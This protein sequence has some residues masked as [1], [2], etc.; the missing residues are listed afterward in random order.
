MRRGRIELLQH[1]HDLGELSHQIGLVLQAPSRVDDERPALLGARALERL[2]GDTGRIGAD[3]LGHHLGADAGAPYLE[4]I[5]GRGA[6]SV[7]RYEHHRG[8]AAH[9]LMR[10]LGRCGGLAGSVHADEQDHMGVRA[11]IERQGLR[12]RLKHLGDL[13]GEH[14]AQR[15]RRQSPVVAG[16]GE[17][18][19]DAPGHGD[20][21]IGLDQRV[22]ELVERLFIE[23]SPAQHR[24]K[25]VAE[26]GRGPSEPLAEPREP[27]SLGVRLGS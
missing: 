19:P 22:L 1:A 20:A 16:R 25:I 10:Q 2:I 11:C 4:L 3:I 17:R 27:A 6:E 7:G 13:G 14:L 5:D 15:L 9:Q 23:L 8:T 12:H 21:E 18:L 24:S 26:S